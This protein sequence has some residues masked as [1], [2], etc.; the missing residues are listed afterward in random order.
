MILLILFLSMVTHLQRHY[1]VCQRI[2]NY[3]QATLMLQLLLICFM[4]QSFRNNFMYVV[5]YLFIKKP[6]K[7]FDTAELLF[8]VS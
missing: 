2:L 1:Y 7:I 4:D 6:R 5:L 3:F 8:L